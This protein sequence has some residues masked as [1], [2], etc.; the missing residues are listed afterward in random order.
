MRTLIGRSEKI[1][2]NVRSPVHKSCGHSVRAIQVNDNPF[3]Y[4]LKRD[5]SVGVAGGSV[6]TSG[7]QSRLDGSAV[8]LVS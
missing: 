3:F 2:G 7:L 8:E 1:R 5:Q 4:F 6:G